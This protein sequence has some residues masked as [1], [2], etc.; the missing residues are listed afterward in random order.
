MREKEEEIIHMWVL[1]N[2][3]GNHSYIFSR[4]RCDK[5]HENIL[6]KQSHLSE[7]WNIYI[8]TYINE[9]QK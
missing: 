4:I 9:S 8:Y 7:H 1:N 6:S 5:N 3:S 2:R